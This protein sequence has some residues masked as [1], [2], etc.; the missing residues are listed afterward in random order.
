MDKR[1]WSVVLFVALAF[2]YFGSLDPIALTEPDEVFYSMTAREMIQNNSYITPLIFG[3]PQFEK[4]PLFYWFLII[5]FKVFGGAVPLAAR[6]VPA[7]CGFL[8]VI[9][10]FIF[11]RRMFG[12]KVA[13]LATLI[14]GTS[15]LYLAMSKAVL[16]DITLSVFIMIAFYAFYLWIVERRD[17]YLY[18]FALF[19][20]LAVLTKGPIAIVIL[21]FSTVIYLSVR[22]EFGILKK[23][24]IHPWVL[25]FCVISVPWYALI[26]AEHGRAFIDEFIVHDNWHRI[27]RAE[28]KNFDHWHFYPM[29]VVT[30]VFPWTFYLLT[31]NEGLKKYKKEYLFFAL[32]FCVTF[33]IFQGC[34]S[35]LASYILPLMPAVV[36]PLSLSICALSQRSRR[37]IVLAVLYGILGVAVLAAPVILAAKFPK[38]MWPTAIVALRVFGAAMIVSAVLLWQRKLMPAVIAQ[39]TGLI[40]MF[41]LVGAQVPASIDR[42]VSNRY[43]QDVVKAENYQGDVVTNKSYSRGIHFQTGNRVVIFDHNKQPFWSPHPIEV[44]S[45]REEIRQFFEARERVLCVLKQSYVE[46]LNGL[47]VN[48]RVT[49]VI[50]QDGPKVVMMSEKIK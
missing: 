44:I 46:D 32:W 6:L 21:L 39:G 42:A 14:M 40:L 10:T 9:A 22:K 12:Q 8:G 15:A 7:L 37:M 50:S 38:Y 31:M 34:H 45:S 18:G 27:L 16:T 36:I 26:V 2:L 5:S 25:V 20:A 41:L 23:F 4:P 17:A 48:Q 35:K 49:R 43:L 30:G 19:A 13:W 28:H 11:C 29:V 3:E 24:L 1:I 33:F 47:F